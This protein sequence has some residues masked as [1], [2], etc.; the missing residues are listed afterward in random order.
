[1]KDR[2]GSMDVLPMYKR[3]FRLKR[4]KSALRPSATCAVEHFINLWAATPVAQRTLSDSTWETKSRAGNRA[5]REKDWGRGREKDGKFTLFGPIFQRTFGKGWREPCSGPFRSTRRSRAASRGPSAGF[6]LATA[7]NRKSA[8]KKKGKM[9]LSWPIS[10]NV[11]ESKA[12]SVKEG[13]YIYK[14]V[15]QKG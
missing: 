5:G 9:K 4:A 11:H 10:L 3:S 15:S 13:K 2:V 12:S 1:M 6:R 14:K 7:G 8:K